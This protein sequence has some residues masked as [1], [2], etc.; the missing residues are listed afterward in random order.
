MSKRLI[1]VNSKEP[2]ACRGYLYRTVL[3]L[4]QYE[5]IYL[6]AYQNV[7]E[8]RHSIAMYF[9]FYNCERLQKPWTTAPRARSSR[10]GR[11]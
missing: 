9:D 10:K 7:A 2:E 6:W 1:P 8:A 4:P 5:E 3:A 11:R